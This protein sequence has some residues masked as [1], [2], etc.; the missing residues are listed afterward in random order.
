MKYA[1]NYFA[2]AFINMYFIYISQSVNFSKSVYRP[3]LLS[4][5]VEACVALVKNLSIN[6]KL[7]DFSHFA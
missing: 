3:N 4:V 6:K 2:H 5:S 7:S 1:T